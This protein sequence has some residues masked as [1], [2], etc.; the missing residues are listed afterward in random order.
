MKLFTRFRN[1][2]LALG[3]VMVTFGQISAQDV[4]YSDSWSR[5]G[6]NL[7]D[8]KSNH[9][10]V[11]FSVEQFSMVPVNVK[12]TSMVSLEMPGVFLPGD[13]GAPNLPGQGRFIAIPTG[14]TPVLRIVNSRVEVIQNVEVAPAPRIP[15]ESE[16]TPLD[17][18]KNST[19]YSS[20][21]FYPAEPVKLSEVS[22]VRGV[23]FVTLGITPFQYNPV[24]KEL[25]VIRDLEVAID[26][27]GGNGEFGDAAFRNRYWDPM[28]SD[29]LLNYSSLPRIDYKSR[30][31]NNANRKADG[32]CEYIIISPDGPE[33]QAWADT[34][35]KF[36]TEQGVITKVFTITEVGG[37]TTT[38]IQN[39][40]KNAYNNW[41]LKPVACL[42]LGD[43]GSDGTKNLLAPIYDNYCVSD[44]LY[45]D[46]NGDMM[47]DVVMSRITANN[48]DQL[49][50]MITKFLNYERNP[51]TAEYFYKHPITALGW[52]TERWFQICSE[53][54]GGYFKHV[55]GKEPVRI[56][57]VYQ[58]TP[59]SV[60]STATNTNTVVNYFGP[61]GLGYIPQ[62]PAELGGWDGGNATMINEAI[63]A[64]SFLLQHRD[65]GEETGWGEPSYHNSNINS[66]T[67]TDLTFIMSINCLT[68][69]YNWGSECF[70][71]KFHRHT[72]NGQN[73][74][75]LG[76]IGASEVS[77]SFVN[78]TYVW[79]VYD[80]WFT[81]FMPDYG[82]TPEPRGILPSF[83]NAAGKYFL[84]QSNWPYNTT[85][86]A[87]TYNLFH[88]HGESFS[89]IYSEIPQAMV[90]DHDTAVFAGATTFDVTAT[91]GATVCVTVDGEIMGV[92][93]AG[94]S[95]MQF[96]FPAA[97]VGQKVVIVAT[98]TNHY[99]YRKEIT[100]TDN[101][102]SAVFQ[103]DQTNH[104][105]TAVVNFTDKSTANPESWEWTF[106][107]G[108]PSTSTER[109]PQGITY[110]APGLY[111][112]TLKVTKGVEV[113]ET[114]I[115]GYIVISTYPVAPAATSAGVCVGLENPALVAEGSNIRWY[116][117]EALTTL[118]GNGNSFVSS[119]TLPGVY[120]Y[121]TTASNDVCQSP[122]TIATLT[123]AAY[124]TAAFAPV[125][126][127][128]LSAAPFTPAEATPA[129]GVFEGDGIVE[130]MFNAAVAGVGDHT[131]RYIYTN[132][133]GCSD[134]AEQVITVIAVPEVSLAQVANTCE[135]GTAVTLT[136]GL[137]EGGT[138]SG[139]GV[140]NGIFNLS[141]A[142]AGTASV[143][144][145]IIDQAT[146]CPSIAVSTFEVYPKPVSALPSDTT[147]CHNW[148]ITLDANVEGATYS[149]STGATTSAISVDSTGVGLQGNKELSVTMTSDKG[150]VNTQKV[151]VD[152]QNCTG[153]NEL[154]GLTRLDIYPNPVS[155]NLN[156]KMETIL[157]TDVKIEVINSFGLKVYQ[158][159]SYT[160][161]GAFNTSFNVSDLSSGVYFIMVKTSDKTI[162]RKIVVRK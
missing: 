147:I 128:C 159:P 49:T 119:E 57:K 141:I 97:T 127:V 143:N 109:N 149:W 79:G 31:E 20:N 156:I 123:I 43:H 65:H 152:V 15:L 160:V 25:R 33:F 140:E 63:N 85:N 106:E 157:R 74:G 117:D 52:Q 86:K 142:G 51:P 29:M 55:Q 110:S 60:W 35:R 8:S 24:T 22:S 61:N 47:P 113:K 39:F 112:V 90:V 94:A 72:K 19:I 83:G 75:A 2:I 9:I 98:M 10:R 42:L 103:A 68:G 139:L 161:E 124:P 134:T 116:S 32:E 88:H 50:V 84:K 3:L 53:V 12:G 138:Y 150:C 104:C 13:E 23:D 115:P 155:D 122:A 118:V 101:V 69:K 130:N 133:T 62:S 148:V 59:G 93:T 151:V 137:P 28:L 16:D 7:V 132:E 21:E 136:G 73:A 17:Y 26:L 108:T 36:R 41:T 37:N 5:Q 78:D 153:I 80:N 27:V 146:G 76:L 48:N 99:R 145:T 67:N 64:G 125:S 45:A 96:T 71:E 6:F 30:Y 82:S 44:N 100:V 56:N 120:T 105:E 66:L 91:E 89:I 92:Q 58:G 135:N 70:T 14:A 126:P 87:V 121:Y 1:A 11:D 158:S 38:A 102:L 144:Y 77:Y 111:T 129:G 154:S 81:D 46:V 4:R 162:T 131:I 40:I 34:I 114:T 54:V 95:A 18:S 107:G